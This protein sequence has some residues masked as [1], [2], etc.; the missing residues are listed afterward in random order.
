M[1]KDEKYKT[2]LSQYKCYT[3][4]SEEIMVGRYSALMDFWREFL[5]INAP[6][7][8]LDIDYQ[9]HK[10]NLF[11]V[12][13]RCDERYVYYYIFHRLKEINE[14]KDV[15][16]YAFWITT[17]KPF[18]V[19]NEKSYI[20]NC[21]NEMFSLFLILGTISE[22]Y[23]KKFPGEKFQYP[24][25]SRIRDIIYDFKYCSVSRES[26]TSFV[27]TLADTY[28]VGIQ[29]ILADIDEPKDT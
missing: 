27:E 12:I 26:M 25:G 13:R 4:P 10:K 19:T 28:G 9:I 23:E 2:D 7:L 15:A 24:S 17:L 21:P 14:Y 8:R 20:Y 1:F 3:E 18:M 11:E 16:L 6:D 29:S 22:I 5:E